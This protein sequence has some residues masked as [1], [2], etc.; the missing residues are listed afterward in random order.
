M[1]VQKLQGKDGIQQP[2]IQGDRRRPVEVLQAASLLET[3]ATQP[4]FD[5]ALSATVHLVA[6]DDLQE[7]CVVQLF[8]AGQ[9]DALGQG[10]GHWPQLETLEQRCEFSDAGHDRPPAARA[11]T[12]PGRAKR[13]AGMGNGS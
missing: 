7:G 10:G 8:T 1:L 5:A 3:G 11:K 12:E 13:P 4:E 6:E 2:A 9:G